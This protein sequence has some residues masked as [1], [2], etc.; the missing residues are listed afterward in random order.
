M[1][2]QQTFL[3]D[4]L[5]ICLQVCI[6]W[7]PHCASQWHVTLYI[8]L[9]TSIKS[10]QWHKHIFKSLPQISWT[11][12]RQK[13]DTVCQGLATL[14]CPPFLHLAELSWF[15]QSAEEKKWIPSNVDKRHF[16]AASL[17]ICIS[18]LALI[19]GP[20]SY[21]GDFNTP[22]RIVWS[23]S[24]HVNSDVGCYETHGHT[25]WEVGTNCCIRLSVPLKP[26][27]RC[28]VT[29]SWGQIICRCSSLLVFVV[30]WGREKEACV[31]VRLT[32]SCT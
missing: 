8:A 18:A 19:S 22:M 9:Q 3:T 17:L 4:C 21:S 14:P 28:W 11:C 31:R 20:G 6:S 2:I 7:W 24:H 12:H 16:T 30:R 29:T 5:F 13:N 15:C 26:P 32:G 27:E 23:Q 1:K 10:Q 25:Q